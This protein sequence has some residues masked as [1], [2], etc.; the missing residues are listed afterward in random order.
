MAEQQAA[1]NKKKQKINAD[2]MPA[3]VQVNNNEDVTEIPPPKSEARKRP[4]GS[5]KAKEALRRGGGEACM[6]AFDK[7]WDKN[8]AFETEKEN[9]KEE[10]FM[11]SF[12][13]E[14]KRLSLDEK[15]CGIRPNR[16]GRQNNVSQHY[17]P[18]PAAAA[19]LHDDA[20]EDCCS[21]SSEL[22]LVH[23]ILFL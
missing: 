11:A 17:Q 9:K 1:K 5:K 23:V 6:E 7:M 19:V 4:M 21:S 18:R 15:K 22:E 20:P 12:E 10:R 14:K 13:L 2:S 3:N 16:K 8:E